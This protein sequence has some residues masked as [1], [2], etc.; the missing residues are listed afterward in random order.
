MTPT[1]IVGFKKA[2]AMNTFQSKVMS[3]GLGHDIVHCELIF[4]T[5][6]K[7]RL[8]AEILYVPFRSGDNEGF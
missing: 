4:S 2:T 1:L 7:V 5:L 8:V 3:Y 6:P